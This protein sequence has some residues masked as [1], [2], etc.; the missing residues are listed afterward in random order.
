MTIKVFGTNWCGSTR[1]VTQ[2]LDKFRIPF[3][4]VDI[5]L[6]A[7]GEDFVVKVNNGYRSVP[8]ILFDDN[9]TLTEPS[10]KTLSEKLINLNL[11]S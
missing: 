11:I 2:L 10:D 7:Q 8:T 5:D 4:Y 1:R 6:N 9:S 3:E